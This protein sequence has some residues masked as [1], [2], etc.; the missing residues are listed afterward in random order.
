MVWPEEVA[1]E[2]VTL[3]V[4]WDPNTFNFSSLL[5]GYPEFIWLTALKASSMMLYHPPDPP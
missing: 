1:Q 4:P 3:K 5:P 2:V